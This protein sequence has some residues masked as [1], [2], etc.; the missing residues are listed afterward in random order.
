MLPEFIIRPNEQDYTWQIV[1]IRRNMPP[2]VVIDGL[3]EKVA[4]RQ[5]MNMNE[6]LRTEAVVAL[7]RRVRA[8]LEKNDEQ[9][10]RM[11]K[12]LRY[13]GLAAGGYLLWPTRD[14]QGRLVIRSHR[15]N[16]KL[17]LVSSHNCSCDNA[18]CW[19][20]VAAVVY[21]LLPLMLEEVAT[22]DD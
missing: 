22:E 12:A 4:R 15:E 9:A 18:R 5:T 1:K 16:G 20:R 10:Q 7:R 8:R 14:G 6:A 21:E 17:I 2:L 19:H 13:F 11:D 3:S